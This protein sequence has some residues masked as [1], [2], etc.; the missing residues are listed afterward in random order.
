MYPMHKNLHSFVFN[1]KMKKRRIF[2]EI[3]N[4]KK[5]KDGEIFL[6]ELKTKGVTNKGVFK[7]ERKKPTP[8]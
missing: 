8:S 6:H 7:K 5:E 4:W 3:F 2:E 1:I